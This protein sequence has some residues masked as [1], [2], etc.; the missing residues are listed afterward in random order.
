MGPRAGLDGRKISSPPGFDPGPSSPSPV[1]IPTELPGSHTHTHTYIY[2]Y[3]CVCVCVC[4]CVSKYVDLNYYLLPFQCLISK[5]ILLEGHVEHAQCISSFSAFSLCQKSKCMVCILVQS[6]H[7][8]IFN[9]ILQTVFNTVE[10]PYA[11]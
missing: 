5:T 7:K 10:V 11:R 3:K 6:K 9:I 2:I 4:V 8:L 1:A